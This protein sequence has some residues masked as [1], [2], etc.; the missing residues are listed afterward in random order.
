MYQN[1][2]F[3]MNGEYKVLNRGIILFNVATESNFI[4]MLIQ[5]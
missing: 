1:K 4:P 5:T 3:F 2:I